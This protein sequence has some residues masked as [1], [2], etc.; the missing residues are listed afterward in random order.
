MKWVDDYFKFIKS[1]WFEFI[2]LIPLGW[3][4]FVFI[5]WRAVDIVTTP[6]LLPFYLTVHLYAWLS[7]VVIIIYNPFKKTFDEMLERRRGY[8]NGEVR[9]DPF[10]WMILQIIF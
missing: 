3:Y 9:M 2:T 8:G 10:L 1:E 7:M 4:I 5:I 6:N